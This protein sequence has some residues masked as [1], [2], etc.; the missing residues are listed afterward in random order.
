ML[1]GQLMKNMLWMQIPFFNS[2][3][4]K[5][6]DGFGFIT[7]KKPRMQKSGKFDKRLLICQRFLSGD[8]FNKLLNAIG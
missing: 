5:F 7:L 8:K 3:P 2:N 6:T 1:H 4:V